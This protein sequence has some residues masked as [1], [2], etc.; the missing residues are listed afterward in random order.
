MRGPARITAA[1]GGVVVL[2]ALGL[3]HTD[4]LATQAAVIRALVD[5]LAALAVLLA[6][7]F[8]RSRVALAAV[9]IAVA[10]WLLRG[11]L[12]AGGAEHDHGRA[13]LAVALPL[14]LGLLA[15]FRDRSLGRPVTVVLLGLALVQGAVAA[16]VA[17]P[18]GAPSGVAG[19][20]WRLLAAPDTARLAF[21][22]AALFLVLGLFVHRGATEMSLVLVLAASAVAILGRLDGEQCVLVLGSAQ[23]VLLVGLVEDSHRLAFHDE[24]T[25]LPGRRAFNEA[26]HALGG[27]FALA[28]VDVDHFKKFNDS[29]GHDVGDQVLRMVATELAAVAGGGRSYRY[30]GEEFAV[31]FAGR[32]PDEAF[33]SLDRVRS[34]IEARRFAIRSPKR[35]REKPQRPRSTSPTR[36][37]KVTVSVGVA[38]AGPQRVDPE[39]VVRAADRA[40]Y[41][42]K[43]GGRNRVVRSS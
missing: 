3:A 36:R 29:F 19:P 2:V 14:N 12:L 33:A 4:L 6:G 11:P 26:L 42:A 8:R 37:V 1:V 25:G 5:L 30:G 38:G 13:L 27:R 28:M 32:G 17:A 31:L 10:S 7:R 34:A 21:L 39:E 35:P 18:S 41:R 40:L 22:V 24:L 23:L 43:E 15:T 20:W 9:L 16:L